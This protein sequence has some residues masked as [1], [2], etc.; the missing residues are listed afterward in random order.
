[1]RVSTNMIYDQGVNAMQR[2]S[3]SMLHTGLQI[4]TGRKI[5][6]P[7]DD[8]VT[9]IWLLAWQPSMG[10]QGRLRLR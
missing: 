1:M 5:L 3:A 2:Q 6:T 9:E 8:P 10:N 7:A 4:S